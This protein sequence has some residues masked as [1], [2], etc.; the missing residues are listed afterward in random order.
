MIDLLSRK[1][2][3]RSR[4]YM[5]KKGYSLHDYQE[6]SV[7]WMLDREI[8][9]KTGGLLAD[10]PGA[11]KTIQATS[12]LLGNLLKQ[13]LIIVPGYLVQQW[14]NFLNEVMPKNSVQNFKKGTVID[15]NARVV[16]TSYGYVYTR[17]VSGFVPTSLHRKIWDRMILDEA[18]IIRN[19]GSKQS[20]GVFA[21]KAKFKWGLTGTPLQNRK[22]DFNVLC[23]LFGTEFLRRSYRDLGE[24]LPRLTIQLY[25][26]PFTDDEE[27][28]YEFYSQP[29]IR[30][31]VFKQRR[32]CIDS[33]L[34][35]GTELTGTPTELIGCS[36]KLVKY[37]HK[38]S[39]KMVQLVTWLSEHPDECSL[40]FTHFRAEQV[41]A[42][43]ILT[44]F[45]YNV[46]CIKGGQSK[47]KRR[48]VLKQFGNSKLAKLLVKKI[49]VSKKSPFLPDLIEDRI[50]SFLDNHPT[51]LIIQIRAGGLGLNLQQASRVYFLSNDYNPSMEDQAI[52]RCYRMG[53]TKPVVVKKFIMYSQQTDLETVEERILD[54]QLKKRSIYVN[55]LGEPELGDNGIEQ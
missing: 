3:V 51:V 39:T 14:L 12:L 41:R 17:R 37:S 15:K 34:Q 22:Y 30:G 52:A 6:K 27:D 5:K 2:F 55:V 28:L 46:G 47:K 50:F 20:Q 32:V 26:I 43:K 9:K 19:K 54:I 33:Y 49:C 7:R 11:G 40:V 53:Q 24:R 31:R 42:S 38:L 29:G 35:T 23:E 4:A 36:G 48:N 8:I 21:L 44:N 25:R 1:A 18:H 13:T 16:L 10:V 45:G